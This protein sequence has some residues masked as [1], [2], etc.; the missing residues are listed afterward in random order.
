MLFTNRQDAGKRLAGALKAFEREGD[1]LVLAIP[2]GGVEI[3]YEIAQ[4]LG[5]DLSLLVARKLPLPM[6][7]ESGFGAVAEDGSLVL[8][9]EAKNWVSRNEIEE[10]IAEQK[11]VIQQRIAILRKGARLPELQNRTVILVDDGIA[12]GSTMQAAVQLCHNARPKKLVIAVPVASRHAI[13]TFQSQVDDMV[14]LT[15]PYPFHAVA[16]VYENWTDVSDD[17][18][19]SFLQEN[20]HG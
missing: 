15:S 12:M 9:R 18:A 5:A 17:E 3:G 10:I 1:L 19:I 16:Q 11:K 7:P 4:A 2:R 6:N 14:A 20:Q 13:D 8:N